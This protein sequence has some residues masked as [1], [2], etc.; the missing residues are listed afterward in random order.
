MPNPAMFHLLVHG[1]DRFRI[2]E[3]A[4]SANG[5]IS[6]EVEILPRAESSSPPPEFVAL[7][8]R[9]IDEASAAH[10]STPLMLDDGAWVAY[11]VVEMMSWPVVMKQRMLESNFTT[12]IFAEI[13]KEIKT[14]S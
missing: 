11:R 8:K 7:L 14:S 6:A 5:L 3:T 12:E 9:V 2:L 13:N 4:V 10:F 1:G